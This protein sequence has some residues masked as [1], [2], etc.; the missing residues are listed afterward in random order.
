MWDLGEIQ[1]Q[2]NQIAV[3]CMMRGYKLEAADNAPP[4][5]WTLDKV[6]A[7]LRIGPPLLS[8]LMDC[9]TNFK[10]IEQ[11]LELVRKFLPEQEH[12]ILSQPR[13][14]KVKRF[15][16]LFGKKYF[17][18]NGGGAGLDM[19]E[20][21]W[22]L[23]IT[24]AGMSFDAYH[25]LELRP[26]Y[27][28]LLSLVVYPYAG[29]EMDQNRV[30]ELEYDALHDFVPDKS[31]FGAMLPVAVKNKKELERRKKRL[32]EEMEKNGPRVPLLDKVQRMIGA[33]TAGRIPLAGWGPEWLHQATDGTRFDGVGRFADWACSNTGCT[34]L[35]YSSAD[36]QYQEGSGE[37]VFLWS[38]GN[39][40]Q[41]AYEWPRVKETRQKIDRIVFW[42][43]AD[44]QRRFTE[45]VDFLCSQ[46]QPKP[47]TRREYDDF[48]HFCPLEQK[49]D[50]DGDE[51]EEETGIES[52]G[53]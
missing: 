35:D 50:E 3:E 48:D 10:S 36:C 38:R 20:L 41:M 17:P 12:D 4:E 43:E 23:P 52:E 16:N 28:L 53:E 31:G 9:C 46:T 6:A 49:G 7:K 30:E 45:L 51:D 34:L 44:P 22:N 15:C 2:N 24:L 25:Q 18:L 26:G 29:S 21:A 42:V 14:E 5:P 33:V 8:A 32:A 19:V 37:P 11:F 27:L 1:R 39:V 13:G 47:G 40:E